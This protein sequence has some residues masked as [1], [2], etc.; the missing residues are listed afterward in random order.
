MTKEKAPINDFKSTVQAAVQR[1][2][3][4]RSIGGGNVTA[5]VMID[6]G[7]IDREF[8]SANEL[9]DLARKVT[10]EIATQLPESKLTPIVVRGADHVTAGFRM[11]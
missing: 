10:D 1:A 7:S 4:A 9:Q 6:A 11:D 3:G 2:L 5:G 8:K